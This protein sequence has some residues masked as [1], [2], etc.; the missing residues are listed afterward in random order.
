MP[1]IG[2]GS[3]LLGGILGEVV[4]ILNPVEDIQDVLEFYDEAT[5]G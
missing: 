2:I 5:E 3:A 1:G 4:D